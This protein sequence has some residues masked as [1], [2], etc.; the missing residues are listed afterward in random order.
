MQVR[1][2]PLQTVRAGQTF[3]ERPGDI[4]EVSRNASTTSPAKFLVVALKAVGQPL[5][6]PVPS[7]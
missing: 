4:H 6:K 3:I 7:K 2:Q 5:T 1:G